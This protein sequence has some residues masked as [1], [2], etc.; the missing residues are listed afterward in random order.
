MDSDL[1]SEFASKNPDS[2][3]RK[4]GGFG[5]G[6]ASRFEISGPDHTTT[7]CHFFYQYNKIYRLALLPAGA[8]YIQLDSNL[9]S[10]SKQL[11]PDSDSR[12]KGWI[13]IQLDSDP[14]SRC[15]DSHITV[16]EV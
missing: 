2:D 16:L 3:S 5:I 7:I 1:D 15:L 9:D 6:F 4:Q 13:R 10:D 12:K 8:F 11:D 14:D